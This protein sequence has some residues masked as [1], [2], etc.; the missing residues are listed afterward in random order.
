MTKQRQGLGR[1]GEELAASYLEKA[2]Y[3]I[4]ARNYRTR[5]AEL[6]IIARRR[7]EL[8]FVE[9]KSRNSTAFGSPLEA[10]TAAKQRKI[11]L[12]AQEYLVR[13][14]L[15]DQASR[16]DVVAVSFR[17]GKP[18]IDHLVNAFEL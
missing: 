6:D 15:S 13:E 7:D 10:I 17:G 2:G 12:A 1:R 18:E 3:R 4:V 11:A 16:F 14:R 5:A 8:V 9:V